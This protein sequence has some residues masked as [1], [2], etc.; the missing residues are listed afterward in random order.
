MCL[1]VV[2]EKFVNPGLDPM[3]YDERTGSFGG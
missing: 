1:P 3:V 2:P